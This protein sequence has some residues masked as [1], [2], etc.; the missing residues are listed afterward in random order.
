ME[1]TIRITEARREKQYTFN[2][3]HGI[4]PTTIIS[5]IKDM[6]FKTSRSDAEEK[7]S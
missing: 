7:A 5:A 4:T 6:G 3:A 1:E 2:V